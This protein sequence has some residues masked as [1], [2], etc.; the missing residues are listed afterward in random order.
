MTL[1]LPTN[2]QLFIF[3]NFTIRLPPH[4]LHEVQTIIILMHP[5]LFILSWPNSSVATLQSVVNQFV[6]S[7][8]GQYGE[9][10]VIGEYLWLIVF[11][12]LLYIYWDNLLYVCQYILVKL[13]A[14]ERYS[15]NK[16]ISGMCSHWTTFL[17]LKIFYHRVFA[18]SQKVNY[19]VILTLNNSLW[20]IIEAQNFIRARPEKTKLKSQY[21]VCVS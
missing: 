13:I 11:N 16:V 1:I 2:S 7:N 5:F 19:D 17:L 4:M 9:E 8:G 21:F 3:C 20:S 14:Q 12:K 10:A 18:G 15:T 6:S